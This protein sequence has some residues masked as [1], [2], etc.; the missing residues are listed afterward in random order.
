MALIEEVSTQAAQDLAFANGA[1]IVIR[2]D[3]IPAIVVP[4]VT[5]PTPTGTTRILLHCDEATFIDSSTYTRT[6]TKVSNPILSTSGKF[7]SCA[8]FSGGYL[9][10]PDADTL[11]FG[12]SD[13]TI[14]CFHKVKTVDGSHDFI[15][16]KGA[17]GNLNN[18]WYFG[19]LNGSNIAFVP[20]N[21]SA[22][23]YETYPYYNDTTTPHHLSLNRV[24]TK[25]N[26][27][28]DGNLFKSVDYVAPYE[29]TGALYVGGWNYTTASVSSSYID[30]FV[31]SISSAL[32]TANFTPPTAPFGS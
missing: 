15:C 5:P 1:L 19:I 30:D 13:W 2:T 29:G 14:E 9:T 24:G 23:F 8:D 32:R 28:I 3:L 12:D 22:T 10:T 6:I 31:I 4:P 16:S 11:R 26:L 21:N 20:K 18:A 17:S 7:G 27:Y 25:L